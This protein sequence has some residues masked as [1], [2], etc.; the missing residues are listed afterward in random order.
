MP[1]VEQGTPPAP[2]RRKATFSLGDVRSKIVE[3]AGSGGVGTTNGYSDETLEAFLGEYYDVNCATW[4]QD[5][6]NDIA[7]FRAKSSATYW[8]ETGCTGASAAVM[9]ILAAFGLSTS[10]DP[11][12]QSAYHWITVALGAAVIIVKAV[13][14][15]LSAAYD[16][17]VKRL[18]AANAFA[19]RVR[20]IGATVRLPREAEDPVRRDSLTPSVTPR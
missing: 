10:T 14:D 11:V 5:F 9:L 12:Q 7:A 3:N 2:K 8:A 16:D 19:K 15:P 13:S 17:A 4:H 20:I 1:Q 18:E 6:L